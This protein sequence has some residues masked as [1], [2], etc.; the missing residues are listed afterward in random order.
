VGEKRGEI[1]KCMRATEGQGGSHCSFRDGC[2][3][4]CELQQTAT[5]CKILQ[6]AATHAATYNNTLQHAAT[7]CNTLSSAREQLKVKDSRIHFAMIG[8]ELY[9]L[10]CNT[11]QQTATQP[12]YTTKIH[13]LSPPYAELNRQSQGD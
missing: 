13:K 1:G 2:W 11:L 5:N 3:C 7:C 6:D 12:W 8:I 4:V 10:Y 9:V